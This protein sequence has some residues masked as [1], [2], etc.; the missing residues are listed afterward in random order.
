MSGMQATSLGWTPV[1]PSSWKVVPLNFVA[2]MGTGHTPDRNKT[3]YWES[4]TIPWVTT[5]DVTRR[6]D[7]LAPLMET[8]QQISEL[9][10]ANS[11]AVLHPTDT[12]MLSRTASVGYSV[13]IGRPMATTQAFVT[14]HA[15][16]DLDP[17]YLLLVLRAMKQEWRKLAYGST[18]LTI[19]MPDLESIRIPLP[20]LEEQ[21]RIADFLDAETARIDRLTHLRSRQAK[22]LEERLG[23]ALDNAFENV[24]YEPTRLKHLLAVKPRYGVLVP[25]FSDSGVRF[26]RVN[27]LLDLAGRADSLA[28][29]PDELSSQY[30]RTVTRP[31]DVLLSVVGTMGRSAVV[32]P[33]LAGANVARAVASLRTR[34]GVSPELLATWLTTPSFLRQASD[35]TG[36]DTAQ[37]T[38][39][40]EDLSNFRL[41]WPVDE[42]GRDELLLITSTIRR[43]QRELT[44]VLEAQR[45]VLA[46][47]RQALIAAAVTGQFDVS[48]ASG[49]TV[50]DGVSA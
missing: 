45:R 11:A 7:S 25:Q 22:L 26:I 32:P 14:W 18:H 33:Q 30:A 37:P 47:R 42:R 15:G 40:M 3:E 36:S 17:R 41:S 31:G 39:G 9:G 43:H 34:Q 2:K 23:L 46:E 49:R 28:K 48:T 21:R 12:V 4:C 24:A 50:T 1:I 6:A 5:P 20:P 16:P 29:I 10:M 44:R 8:E 38:L 35:V 13:R 27:D 19:Y